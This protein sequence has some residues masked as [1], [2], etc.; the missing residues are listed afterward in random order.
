MRH[1]HDAFS[2]PSGLAGGRCPKT[3][4]ERLPHPVGRGVRNGPARTSKT[5]AAVREVR[6]VRSSVAGGADA[7]EARAGTKTGEQETVKPQTGSTRS[8]PAPAKKHEKRRARS[9]RRSRRVRG[10]PRQENRRT[11]NI[12]RKFLTPP[13]LLFSAR[14]AEV[15]HASCSPVLGPSRGGFSC[16]LFSC[17]DLTTRAGGRRATHA[18]GAGRLRR[19]AEMPAQRARSVRG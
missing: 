5:S 2:P 14:R 19:S 10:L 3:F 17:S 8:R 13:V 9:R 12:L 1:R 4:E 11:G 7:F 15:P 6:S 18:R 16:L